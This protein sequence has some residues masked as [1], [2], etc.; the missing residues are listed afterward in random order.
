M[1]T[2]GFQAM[3][4]EANGE[5]DAIT[6]KDAKALL[7]SDDVVF[8]DV[9]EQHER[10]AGTIPTSVHAPRGFLEFIADPAGPMH[11]PAFASGRQ[12]V[13]FCGSGGRSALASKTLQDM[14]IG[15]VVNLVGGFQAWVQGGGEVT[16]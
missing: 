10:D 13:I 12:L 9:R 3:L 5:V 8:I 1:V 15:R 7:A 2:K 11:H 6:V 14:G 16:S 4:A